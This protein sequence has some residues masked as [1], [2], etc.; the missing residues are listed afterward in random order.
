MTESTARWLL[1]ALRDLVAAD[2]CN[3]QRETMRAEGYFDAARR[4][5]RAADRELGRKEADA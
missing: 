4:A 5:V 3:Y 2:S 1:E